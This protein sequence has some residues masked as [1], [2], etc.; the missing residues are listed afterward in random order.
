MKKKFLRKFNI[1][2]LLKTLQKVGTKGTQLNI[3]NTV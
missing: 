2:L 1:H 3:I